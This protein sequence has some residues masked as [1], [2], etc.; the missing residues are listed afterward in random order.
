MKNLQPYLC[1]KQCYRL[2]QTQNRYA[3]KTILLVDFI[4]PAA[5]QDSNQRHD[6]H[7]G[8]PQQPGLAQRLPETDG[9]ANI[10]S[11]W[12][13]SAI[14]QQDVCCEQFKWQLKAFL[15]GS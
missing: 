1:E 4:K 13:S 10:R 8:Q 11:Y 12:Y 14:L 15:F 3:T 2:L 7:A 6:C 9:I 5:T